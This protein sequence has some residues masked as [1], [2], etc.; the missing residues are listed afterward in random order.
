M[1]LGIHFFTNS[2]WLIQPHCAPVDVPCPPC[3]MLCIAAAATATAT[4]LSSIDL[5]RVRRRR[6]RIPP[7]YLF[8]RPW[9]EFLA[10]IAMM[11]RPLLDGPLQG[12]GNLPYEGAL[13]V[14]SIMNKL[15]AHSAR[16]SGQ[17]RALLR[18]GRK[19]KRRS[20]VDRPEI[21]LLSWI[22]LI[23]KEEALLAARSD[24]A[25][26]AGE[27]AR[28]ISI[29]PALYSHCAA[30]RLSILISR[31]VGRGRSGDGGGAVFQ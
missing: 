20:S 21:G 2:R 29:I 11:G 7:D 13:S 6:R 9:P 1:V 14:S 15:G 12:L 10:A 3:L 24:A 27:R 22:S 18:Q 4:V 25:W 19:W 30:L 31:S 26:R 17:P 16:L 8:G 23:K 5:A 28:G